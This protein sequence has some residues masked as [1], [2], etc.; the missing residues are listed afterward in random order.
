MVDAGH[1]GMGGVTV[2]LYGGLGARDGDSRRADKRRPCQ[3][4]RD[5]DQKTGNSICQPHHRNLRP[6]P[7]LF[8]SA[9]RRKRQGRRIGIAPPP[10]V[11]IETA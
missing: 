1:D 5:G 4:K 9:T 2:L 3:H 10:K 7:T 11:H 6:M 8:K